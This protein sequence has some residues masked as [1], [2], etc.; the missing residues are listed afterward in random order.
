MLIITGIVAIA[1]GLL[2]IYNPSF[3]WKF[4]EGW[5]VRGES[6]PSE[7]YLS[8]TKFCGLISTLFGLLLLIAGIFKLIA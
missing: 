5:K 8:V 1:L 2:N 3:S 4:N 6:E 7:T